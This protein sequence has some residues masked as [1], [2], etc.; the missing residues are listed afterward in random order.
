SGLSRAEEI[1]VTGIAGTGDMASL[2]DTLLSLDVD[3]SDIAMAVS[4]GQVDASGTRIA[5]VTV[6]PIRGGIAVYNEVVG[7]RNTTSDA[8]IGGSNLRGVTIIWQPNRDDPET[9]FTIGTGLVLG[10]IAGGA[11]LVKL[12]ATPAEQLTLTGGRAITGDMPLIGWIDQTTGSRS[13]PT[14]TRVFYA[15]TPDPE[16]SQAAAE[17]GLIDPTAVAGGQIPTSI[18]DIVAGVADSGSYYYGVSGGQPVTRRVPTWVDP[19]GYIKVPPVFREADSTTGSQGDAF[20]MFRGLPDSTIRSVQQRMID[21]GWAPYTQTDGIWSQEWA[22]KMADLMALANQR[23]FIGQLTD[24]TTTTANAEPG[25]DAKLGAIT[26]AL[27]ERAHTMEQN[28]IEL[29]SYIP[30]VRTRVNPA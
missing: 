19:R 29:P 20:E 24:Q 14:P 16:V 21:A 25:F 2:I 1:I 15:N 30:Q 12:D 6:P 5:V 18:D 22:I 28:K 8:S 17:L 10:G 27:E 13:T 11:G 9:F 26:L 4:G 3:S 7:A 23:G